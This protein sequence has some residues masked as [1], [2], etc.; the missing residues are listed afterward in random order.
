MKTIRKTVLLAPLLAVMCATAPSVVITEADNAKNVPLKKGQI[1]QLSLEAQLSTGY[2]WKIS[3]LSGVEA[4]GD[5]EV[6]TASDIMTG[7]KD[8][9]IMR[10]R[11]IQSGSGFIELKYIRPWKPDDAP[12]KYYKVGVTVAE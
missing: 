2:G 11:A 12:L 10:F 8:I 6:K 9:Q 1:L 7:G 3:G 4:Y 5:I